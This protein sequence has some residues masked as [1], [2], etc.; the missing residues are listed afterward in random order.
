MMNLPEASLSALFLDSPSLCGDFSGARKAAGANL[1]FFTS[2]VT[3]YWQRS[4][5]AGKLRPQL[6][7]KA[8][9]VDDDPLVPALADGLGRV[10]R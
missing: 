3:R 8:L 2:G 7:A 6:G 5:S 4:I 1:Q 9:G 10:V